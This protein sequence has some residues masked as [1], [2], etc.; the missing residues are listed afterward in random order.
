M[1]F[2]EVTYRPLDFEDYDAYFTIRAY[3][4]MDD[5]LAG[6]VVSGQWAGCIL[7]KDDKFYYG[8]YDNQIT[9][10]CLQQLREVLGGNPCG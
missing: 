9:G 4:S 7:V 3:A 5:F 6:E 2:G 1:Q 10:I 8:S